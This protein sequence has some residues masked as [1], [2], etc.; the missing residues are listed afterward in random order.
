MYNNF[1]VYSISEMSELYLLIYYP[2]DSPEYVKTLLNKVLYMLSYHIMVDTD[3]KYN[4]GT[5]T[6]TSIN[7]SLNIPIEKNSEEEFNSTTLLINRIKS[8]RNLLNS[9][10]FTK[11]KKE[12]QYVLNC[13]SIL[14]IPISCRLSYSDS[15]YEN[16]I[17][18]NPIKHDNKIYENEFGNGCL[19]RQIVN[20]TISDYGMYVNISKP[21]NEYTRYG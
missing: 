13:L 11:E 3:V 5:I 19:I 8:I 10:D 18:Y 16:F 4:P 1:D 9:I 6:K 15:I 12:N 14:N 2:N 20:P 7:A 17:L 21:Y